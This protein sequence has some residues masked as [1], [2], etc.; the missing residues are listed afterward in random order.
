MRNKNTEQVL[1]GEEGQKLKTN[2]QTGKRWQLSTGFMEKLIDITD[3]LL[4]KLT[5]TNG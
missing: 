5:H 1:E 4:E 3:K 2:I